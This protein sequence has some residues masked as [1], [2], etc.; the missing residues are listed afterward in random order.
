MASTPPSNN[1]PSTSRSSEA[2]SPPSHNLR[3]AD[4]QGASRLLRFASALRVTLRFTSVLCRNAGKRSF[5]APQR[6]TQQRL[7]Q[8][9]RHCCSSNLKSS[10]I[11]RIPPKAP[12]RLPLR[13]RSGARDADLSVTGAR[14][15]AFIH[16]TSARQG[17]LQECWE[18]TDL[19]GLWLAS[20]LEALRYVAY[21]SSKPQRSHL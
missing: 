2:A 10:R 9:P 3:Y 5:P 18:L 20:P 6:K 17:L 16:A 1:G 12:T 4:R 11:T 15:E 8:C 13:R 7:V 19:S 21:D 14:T